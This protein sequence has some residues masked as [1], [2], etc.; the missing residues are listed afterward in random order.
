MH[1]FD[2]VRYLGL[3]RLLLWWIIMDG[4]TF[5]CFKNSCTINFHYKA[6]KSQ[7]ILNIS[8]I[9][10]GWKKKVIYTWMAWV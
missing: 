2:L 7:N 8:P 5:L 6:W 3:C 9:V 1:H 4:C 10:F